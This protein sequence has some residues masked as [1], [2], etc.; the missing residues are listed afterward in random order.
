L[1]A[2][3][4][5]AKAGQTHKVDRRKESQPAAVRETNRR[6]GRHR[7]AGPQLLTEPLMQRRDPRC[8]RHCSWCKRAVDGRPRGRRSA[9]S[10]PP[11]WPATSAT[12]D[13]A[14][15]LDEI[16]NSRRPIPERSRD[17]WKSSISAVPS[18]SRSDVRGGQ[19]VKACAWFLDDEEESVAGPGQALDAPNLARDVDCRAVVCPTRRQLSVADV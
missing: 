3:G 5:T 17:W 7:I 15:G 8:R 14:V 6:D 19:D 4:D 13:D 10:A 16:R 9:A 2:T 1:T 11:A 18:M 12:L